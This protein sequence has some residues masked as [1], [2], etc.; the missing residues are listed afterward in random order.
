MDLTIGA[1]EPGCRIFTSA[2]KGGFVKFIECTK[3]TPGTIILHEEVTTRI[4]RI[5]LIWHMV[6]RGQYRFFS[7][8]TGRRT[9]PRYPSRLDI[10]LKPHQHAMTQLFPSGRAFFI[11]P[12]FVISDPIGFYDFVY[13]FSVWCHN[14]RYIISASADFLPW[15]QSLCMEKDQE[16]MKHQKYHRGEA[17]LDPVVYRYGLGKD[18]TDAILKAWILLKKIMRDYGDEEADTTVR[19]VM[20][21][22]R[23]IDPND[24]QSLVNWY[25]WWTTM[26]LDQH[27]RF[28]VLGSNERFKDRAYRTV[29][30]PNYD[31]DQTLD[32]DELREKNR[33][34]G[35]AEEKQVMEYWGAQSH[36]IEHGVTTQPVRQPSEI[37][38][39]RAAPPHD[40]QAGAPQP[41]MEF[42][43]RLFRSD[44]A[45]ELQE[46]LRNLDHRGRN[47]RA[48]PFFQPVSWENLQMA[49]HFGDQSCQ[50][51]NY[52]HWL[53]S[54]SEFWK[55]ANTWVGLFYTPSGDWDPEK[56]ASAYTRHPWIAV[57]R[58]VNPHFKSPYAATEL[59]IWDLAADKEAS[60]SYMQMRLVDFVK[61]EA[62]RLVSPNYRLE[63]VWY[64]DEHGRTPSPQDHPLDITCQHLED[65]VLNTQQWLPPWEKHIEAKGWK[66]LPPSYVTKRLRG[67]IRPAEDPGAN[68]TSAAASGP[69][70]ADDD[71]R[72]QQH[73]AAAGHRKPFPKHPDDEGEP[74]AFV[75]L[76]PRG[77]SKQRPSRCYNDLYEAAWSA[78][79]HDPACRAFRHTFRPTTEWYEQQRREGRGCSHV[80]V[81]AGDA[82][83]E[84]L[85]KNKGGD[86]KPK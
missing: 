5:P 37:V 64:S 21:A 16:L 11:T 32:P 12:S 54:C 28:Y 22:P 39:S 44:R 6:D 86:R 45:F 53:S 58:P 66:R 72:R 20:W 3:R 81:D 63:R 41:G 73:G 15:L 14:P 31:P 38:T 9:P 80:C 46:W 35:E 4:R 55:G 68:A 10:D 40:P 59:F 82:I 13:W 17:G 8:A 71:H 77:D 47:S 76:P 33:L 18:R 26:F 70:G 78:R 52:T 62:A 36:G 74:L 42:P 50:Y 85:P 60:L 7:L 69:A 75:W 19:K 43:T 61:R 30:V 1:C 2:V 56:P 23:E 57:L 34:K 65:L 84:N 24:E 49:D 25:L 27:R 83:L 67:E 51:A 29:R 79:A 48:T